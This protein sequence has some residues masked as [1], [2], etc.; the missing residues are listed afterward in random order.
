MIFQ[1]PMTALNP[2]ERVGDQIA[3]AISLHNKVTN[4][5][6]ALRAMDTSRWSA[7]P[8]RGSASSRTSSRAA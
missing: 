2:I 6:A 1:D 5:E 4:A 8:G 3:E 7:S